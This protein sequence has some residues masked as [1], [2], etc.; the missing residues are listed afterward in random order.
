M[1][2]STKERE[3]MCGRACVRVHEEGRVVV[4]VSVRCVCVVGVLGYD[5]S[6]CTNQCVYT[7]M[8]LYVGVFSLM[9]K[10]MDI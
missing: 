8:W 2:R 4:L 10:S 5:L 7:Y 6:L 3:S 9:L 1:Y